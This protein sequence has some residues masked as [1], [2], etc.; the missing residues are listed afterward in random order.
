MPATAIAR[1]Q[2][3]L[4]CGFGK[5]MRL[6]TACASLLHQIASRIAFESAAASQPHGIS[7]TTGLLSSP[8]PSTQMSTVSPGTTGPTPDGV[9]VRITSPGCSVIAELR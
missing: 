4:I 3:H 2:S 6:V 8:T 9:P 1:Q 7:A 5:H